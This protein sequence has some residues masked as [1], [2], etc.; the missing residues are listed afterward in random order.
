ML[1]ALLKECPGGLTSIFLRPPSPPSVARAQEQISRPGCQCTTTLRDSLCYLKQRIS[2]KV[3]NRAALLGFSNQGGKSCI[4]ACVQTVIK[5]RRLT[6]ERLFICKSSYSACPTKLQSKSFADF[7]KL[8]FA[9]QHC[10]ATSGYS[11]NSH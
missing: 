5:F 2:S 7:I 10:P 6:T 4:F 9:G 8:Y 3:P 1:C 11:Q